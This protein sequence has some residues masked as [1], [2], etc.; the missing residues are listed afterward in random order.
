M[1]VDLSR[2]G[3]VAGPDDVHADPALPGA[4]FLESG[5][6]IEPDFGNDP[7][8]LFV[9]CGVEWLGRFNDVAWRTDVPDGTVDFIPKAWREVVD[10]KQTIELSLILHIDPEPVIKASANG[11]TAIYR[12]TTEDPPAATDPLVGGFQHEDGSRRSVVA[13]YLA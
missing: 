9:H 7:Y 8:R 5:E 6:F 11:H 3:A 12:P 4:D 1:D 10:E 13:W 2:P